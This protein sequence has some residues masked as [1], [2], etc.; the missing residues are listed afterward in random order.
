MSRA[1]G[2]ELQ[3]TNKG[4]INTCKQSFGS[5]LIKFHGPFYRCVCRGGELRML[6]AVDQPC[7][8][9]LQEVWVG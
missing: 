7:P 3:A 6:L 4:I 8:S 9:V 1:L 2:E 5:W